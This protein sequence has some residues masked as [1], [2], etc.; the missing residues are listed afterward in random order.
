MNSTKLSVFI[1]Y[2]TASGL[3]YAREAKR[4]LTEAGYQTWMWETDSASGDDPAEQIA[5]NIEQCDIFVYLCTKQDQ[6]HRWNGQQYERNLAWSL[7][8]STAIVTLEERLIPLML[9]AYR[10]VVVVVDTFRTQCRDVVDELAEAPK[11][12][13]PAGLV[14]EAEPLERAG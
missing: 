13:Q 7:N 4:V 1:S 6:A 9:R 5:E 3:E 11:L 2:D 12:K 10:H 14:G 8:K